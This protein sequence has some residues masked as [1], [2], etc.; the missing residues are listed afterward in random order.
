MSVVFIPSG[1]GAAARIQLVANVGALPAAAS[2]P[3][4]SV[5]VTEDDGT[6]YINDGTTW[7]SAGGGGAGVASINGLTGVVTI[8][9]Y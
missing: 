3:I 4:G 9:I 7:N 6:L 2:V 8:Q 1:G 5:R